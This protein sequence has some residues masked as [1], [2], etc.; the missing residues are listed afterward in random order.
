[1]PI[2]HRL[3]CSRA[4]VGLGEPRF[5]PKVYMLDSAGDLLGFVIGER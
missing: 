3:G 5:A 2:F 1:M 4:W